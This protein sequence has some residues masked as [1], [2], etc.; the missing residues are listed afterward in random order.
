MSNLDLS[1]ISSEQ[2]KSHQYTQ[3]SKIRD[4]VAIDM[5]Y[6]LKKSIRDQM[7][8]QHIDQI[9]DI[10]IPAKNNGHVPRYSSLFVSTDVYDR[11]MKLEQEFSHIF[12]RAFFY[13]FEFLDYKDFETEEDKNN[14]LV[15]LSKWVK[16]DTPEEKKYF[17][18][19][20]ASYGKFSFSIDSYWIRYLY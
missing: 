5:S 14:I 13:S 15:W 4:P 2:I 20:L 18:E 6:Y 9:L 11:V 12:G 1:N 16:H 17:E 3:I 7:V 19:V 10:I 8:Q